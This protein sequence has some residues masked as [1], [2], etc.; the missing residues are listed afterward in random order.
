M[1]AARAQG[2]GSV[3]VGVFEEELKTLLNIPPH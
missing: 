2:L 3:F 1:L